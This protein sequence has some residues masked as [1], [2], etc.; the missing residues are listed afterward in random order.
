MS[1]T[2]P[3]IAAPRRRFRVV[4]VVSRE[5]LT[6]RMIRIVF[7]GVDLQD[8]AA[9]EF[10]D[11]YVKLQFPPPGADYGPPF[12]AEELRTTHPRELW[13]RTRTY[14][15]SDWDPAAGELTIDFVVHGDRG[16]A[17]PWAMAARPGDTVQLRGPGGAYTP[18]PQAD[19]HLMVGDAAALPAITASLR[20][21]PSGAPVHVIAQIADPG[22]QVAL[23]CPGELDLRWVYEPGPDALL[24][25]VRALAWREGTVHAFVHGEASAVRLLRRHLFADRGLPRELASISGYWKQDRTEEGWRE[26]KADWN[27]QVEADLATS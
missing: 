8:F 10:T 24:A 23:E 25:A 21:I 14:T 16:V 22:E 18:D 19:W 13:P 26:D 17:G 11:H 12:D 7:D 27:R 2:T 20:R 6:P 5:A 3:P 15:V 9:E 1:L 4:R